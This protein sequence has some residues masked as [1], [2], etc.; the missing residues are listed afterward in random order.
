M[1]YFV[2][3]N[4]GLAS[5]RRKGFYSSAFYSQFW[6]GLRL[7]C[8]HY[9]FC[10]QQDGNLPRRSPT[11]RLEQGFGA[12]GTKCGCKKKKCQKKKRQSNIIWLGLLIRITHSNTHRITSMEVSIPSELLKQGNLKQ[13]NNFI[14]FPS[15]CPS[16]REIIRTN[17]SKMKRI[18]NV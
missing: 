4:P 5:E 17:E 7:H 9:F 2:F 12:E 10:G 6:K 18:L 14:P 1:Q 8:M 3:N 13:I 16:Q 15:H 11:T